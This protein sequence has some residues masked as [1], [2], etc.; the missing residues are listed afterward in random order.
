MTIIRPVAVVLLCSI[1]LPRCAVTQSIRQT[2]VPLGKALD[3]ALQHGT[4]IGEGAKPFHLKVHV[5]ESTNPQSDYHAEI[6]EFWISS[7]EWRRSIDSPDFKQTIVTNNGQTDEEDSGEYYPLWLKGVITALFDPVPN[8]ERWDGM[9]ANITQ[10]TLPNGMRSDACAREKFKI[11]SEAV[12][13][14][15]FG[16]VCF[17]SE[18]LL[19]FVGSPGYSM[20][21][22]D[23]QKFD[24]RMVARTLREDPEPGTTIVANVIQ[25][26]ELKKPDPSLF[27]ITQPTPREKRI[28]SVPVPQKVIEAAADGNLSVSWPTVQSG[29]TSGLLSMYVSVD[30]EGRIREAYPLNSDNAGLQDAV[31]DQLLKR[32]LKPMTRN[33]IPVQAE[34]ALSF[35]FET[36]L[37]SPQ[38]VDPKPGSLDGLLSGVGQQKPAV[39]IPERVRVSQGVTQGLIIRK[40]APIY[41]EEAR[42]TRVEGSVVMSAVIGK[43]GSVAKLEVLSGPTPLVDAAVDA[44]KQWK[45]RPYMLRG[46]PVEVDTQITVNFQLR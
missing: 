4:L 41:P 7:T 16:N 45:Y 17:D 19:K 28:E 18:R 42:K 25:L 10:I 2:S 15:A 5:F 30:R 12:Q 39:G 11:G 1:F 33:G 14:D 34:S 40:V 46:E 44:V 20:E 36:Q 9:G 37:A 32:K 35:R 26:E 6:E 24:K 3:Y 29:K 27:A 23:Y 38:G 31:R 13:N 22:H 8:R 21:F 43:D